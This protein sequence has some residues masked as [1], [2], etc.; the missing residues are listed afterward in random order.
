MEGG[1]RF[2]LGARVQ[3]PPI[4]FKAL[5]KEP[6]AVPTPLQQTVVTLVLVWLKKR[7]Y[8]Q[9]KPMDAHVRNYKI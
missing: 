6:E 4:V 8:V 3:S 2:H 5:R 7:R 1:H 9:R